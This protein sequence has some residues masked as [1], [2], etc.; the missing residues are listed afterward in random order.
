MKEAFVEKSF[1]PE[2]L[3]TV[4]TVNAILAEYEADGY[5]LTL[6]Q[7]Y[8]QLVARG[9]TENSQR[10]YKRL[11]DLVNNARLA[12]LID[13]AMIEDRGRE[14]ITPPHW[15]NP[16]EIVNAAAS[17]FAV[18]KWADQTNHVEVMV[19]KQ[20]LEGVLIPVCR[21]LDIPFTANKGYSSS[22]TMY[23]AGKR[24][25]DY[26]AQGKAI[27]VL[28]LGDHDPSGIDMTRDV[29]DRLTLFTGGYMLEVKRLALNFDQVEV[30]KPPENPAK[31][32]DARFAAYTARFGP[33]SWELD[34][35][36]PRTLAGL[37]TTAVEGLRDPVLWAE[38]VEREKAM[39]AELEAFARRYRNGKAT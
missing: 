29:D 22:S 27:W 12:G 13:W 20:A 5:T 35:I 33:S 26:A 24:L 15:R 38:A 16:G 6:R 21:S 18:D 17:Q 30:L 2:S 34:A 32:T 14:T 7:L 1:K 39:R 8:Y 10:S 36:E 4:E 9:F 23:E 25:A 28:Y 19:E 31:E 37:V 3:A 11:G